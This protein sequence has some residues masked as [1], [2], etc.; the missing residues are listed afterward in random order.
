MDGW[1]QVMGRLRD[2]DGECP[3]AM[4]VDG[5]DWR[6]GETGE[7]GRLERREWREPQDW[8]D[9]DGLCP[10]GRCLFAS[11]GTLVET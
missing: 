6:T 9:P 7:T 8:G 11:D 3:Q 1:L 5:R 4:W 2:S 10:D